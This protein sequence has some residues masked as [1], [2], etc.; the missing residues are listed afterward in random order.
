MVLD[1]GA[2]IYAP[3]LLLGTSELIPTKIYNLFDWIITN[4]QIDDGQ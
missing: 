3:L 2:I 4:I 1:S